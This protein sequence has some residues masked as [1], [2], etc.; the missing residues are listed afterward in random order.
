MVSSEVGSY[1]NLTSFLILPLRIN[2]LI[3]P[4][5]LS[6][7]EFLVSGRTDSTDTSA[8]ISHLYFSTFAPLETIQILKD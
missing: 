1:C 3:I 5:A 2:K 6:G 8:Y 4:Y 7:S